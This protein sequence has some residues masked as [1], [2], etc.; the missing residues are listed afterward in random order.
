M[1]PFAKPGEFCPNQAC[2]DYQKLQAHQ[3]QPH[4]VKAG[5]TRNGVQRYRCKTCGKY[6]VETSGTIFYRKRTPEHEILETLALLAEG[7]RISSLR[8]VKGHKEDTILSWLRQAARHA[9]TLEDVLMQDFRV[10]RGQL[11]ALWAYVG[12]K[13]QKKPP[14]N[15]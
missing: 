14:G 11:D 6:F 9:E 2:P 5:K 1:K 10:K 12:H 3:G 4:V 8:R 13:G 15:A 7:N